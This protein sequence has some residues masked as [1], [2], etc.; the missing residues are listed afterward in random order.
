MNQPSTL[1]ALVSELERSN[2]EVKAARRDV[3]MRVARIVRFYPTVTSV[4]GLSRLLLTLADDVLGDYLTGAFSSLHVVSAHFDGVGTFTARTT[5][6]LPMASTTGASRGGHAV[7]GPAT[8]GSDRRARVPV[9]HAVRVLAQCACV[10]T[11]R[12]AHRHSVGRGMA[13]RPRQESATVSSARRE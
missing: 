5:R 8:P 4:G 7:R 3:D 13:R 11:P 2:P 1:S 6:V 10:R 9:F 12:A